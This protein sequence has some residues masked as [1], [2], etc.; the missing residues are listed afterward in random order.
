MKLVG[1]TLTV[2]QGHKV[3]VLQVILL[4]SF[5]PFPHISSPKT[6]ECF[7]FTQAQLASV[8]S[9]LFSPNRL[10]ASTSCKTVDSPTSTLVGIA[11][12]TRVQAFSTTT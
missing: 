6:V 8:L 5:W 10:S 1:M 12:P 7:L 11:H 2:S 3:S 9:K 4:L